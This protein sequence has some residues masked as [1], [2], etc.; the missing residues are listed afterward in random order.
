MGFIEDL[1]QEDKSAQGGGNGFLDKLRGGAPRL[2]PQESVMYAPVE[3]ADK[4]TA[5][6]TAMMQSSFAD[7]PAVQAKIF[8]AAMFPDEPVSQAAQRFQLHEGNWV[9]R[10]NDGKNY[11][12]E[13]EGIMG[14]LK[15]ASAKA[16]AFTMVAAPSVAGEMVAGPVG[17]AVGG[18][19]G[20]A[21]VQGIGSLAF[22]DPVDYGKI[23]LEGAAGFAGAK[24]GKYVG[25][26]VD[27]LK[28]RSFTAPQRSMAGDIAGFEGGKY[29][30]RL[31]NFGRKYGVKL[32]VPQ[33][34]DNPVLTAKYNTLRGSPGTSQ[35]IAAF[36][37]E[38]TEQ[39]QLA[40]YR[41]LDEISPQSDPVIAGRNLVSAAQKG[42]SRLNQQRTAAAAP[43]YSQ[44]D[45][46]REMV[47]ITDTM[48]MLRGQLDSLPAGGP[49]YKALKRVK[50]FLGKQGA[51]KERP[52]LFDYR[53]AKVNYEDLPLKVRV[54]MT[55]QIKKDIDF[56]LDGLPASNKVGGAPAIKNNLRS[57]LFDLKASLT[58]AADEALPAYGTARKVFGDKSGPIDDFD[59]SIL[60]DIAKSEKDLKVEKAALDLFDRGK[61]V[62]PVAMARHI[63]S[64]ESPEA[65]NAAVRTKL[66][67]EIDK[68]VK[69]LASGD[70]ANFGSRVYQ[71]LWGDVVLRKKLQ[72]AMTKQQFDSL[73]NFTHLM[74]RLGR[75]YGKSAQMLSK[76]EIQDMLQQ[77]ATWLPRRMAV[78][79]TS[80]II[81]GRNLISRNLLYMKTQ[82]YQKALADELLN[83]DNIEILAKIK[84]LSPASRQFIEAAGTFF[85]TVEA[86]ALAQED[87]YTPITE[88]N[89]VGRGTGVEVYPH[90]PASATN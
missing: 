66:Q 20:E 48:K 74:Q 58:E 40:A 26:G 86:R 16:P 30:S 27:A 39:A 72:T 70:Y 87:E 75:T 71:S 24:I 55:D 89:P 54:R 11:P 28:A 12:V 13:P 33:A 5:S 84:T 78:G 42:R 65:W 47:D 35:R 80:P 36:D 25:K 56:I 77:E 18:M 45:A 53:G 14:W 8:A 6:W 38:Q 61:S 2:D 79:L 41:F 67:T 88:K 44:V 63:I 34:L 68:A 49:R 73:K 62:E 4:P 17:A 10:D 1:R 82:R 85:G 76:N 15:G 51:D 64:N 7:D 32:N 83:P 9:Y 22:D 52:T 23:G 90:G 19:A 43:F 29:A 60:G 31:Y 57:K 3:G 37:R 81:S 69:P 59:K 21:A 46:S 50:T